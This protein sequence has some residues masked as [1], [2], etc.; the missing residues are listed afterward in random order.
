MC[1]ISEH[2][3]LNEADAPVGDGGR[4]FHKPKIKSHVC[5]SVLAHGKCSYIYIWAGGGWV[6]RQGEDRP[7]HLP[8]S[9]RGMN[10][11]D[12]PLRAGWPQSAH[13]V[14]A[15]GP[16]P[17]WPLRPHSFPPLCSSWFC[18]VSSSTD[19]G[20]SLS[21]RVSG[22]HSQHPRVGI[23]KGSNP[24]SHLTPREVWHCYLGLLPCNY[25][26]SFLYPDFYV[27]HF[28]F[29]PVGRPFDHTAPRILSVPLSRARDWVG[30]Q[31]PQDLRNRKQVFRRQWAKSGQKQE[32]K[33]SAGFWTRE[34]GWGRH[35]HHMKSAPGRRVRGGRQKTPGAAF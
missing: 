8:G 13:R 17:R 5:P 21:V 35:L 34:L 9:Q 18:L 6:G 7:G 14:P 24:H 31:E 29:S 4:E 23:K 28:L 1:S 33:K 20:H 22:A 3:Y 30:G 16:R 25:R 27:S 11:G 2:Q 15:M 12:I 32:P 19:P 26:L 10:G